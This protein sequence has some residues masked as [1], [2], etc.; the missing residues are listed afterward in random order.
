MEQNGEFKMQM[1]ELKMQ[2]CDMRMQIGEMK[3]QIVDLK[4]EIEKRKNG[5]VAPGNSISFALLCVCVALLV[6]FMWK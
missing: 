3:M 6:A 4:K 5:F 1:C 2:M